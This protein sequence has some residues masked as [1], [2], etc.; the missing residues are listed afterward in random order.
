[1]CEGFLIKNPP[2]ITYIKDKTLN[3][4]LNLNNTIEG[5]MY[6]FYDS[7]ALIFNNLSNH[8]FKFIISYIQK[9]YK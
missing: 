4:I 7:P 1:M 6:R 9:I 8:L 3:K 2:S 5:K